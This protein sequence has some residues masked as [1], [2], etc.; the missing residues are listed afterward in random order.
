MIERDQT[1]R[2]ILIDAFRLIS[3]FNR[4][5]WITS[6]DIRREMDCS[7]KTALRWL[8]SMEDAGFTVWRDT[9]GH[10]KYYTGLGRA[11]TGL[12]ANSSLIDPSGFF[13][14]KSDKEILGKKPSAV[15]CQHKC[16]SCKRW[17]N[18]PSDQECKLYPCMCSRVR[19]DK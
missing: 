2:R 1:R 14:R 12:K 15:F 8:H 17:R 6:D 19:K 16:E 4:Q 5:K 11:G 3:L 10:T 13:P 18:H 9:D 7:H